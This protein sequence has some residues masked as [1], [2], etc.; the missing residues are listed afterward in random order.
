MRA[1]VIYA[2]KSTE[3]KRG[4]IPTSSTTGRSSLPSGARG[5]GRAPRTRAALADHG[6]RGPVSRPLC[7]V[8]TAVR[9]AWLLRADRSTLRPACARRRQARTEPRRD[10]PVGDKHDVE[11]SAS[12]T[13]RYS[14]AATSRS[15][16]GAI[17][18]MK[19]H[20][21]SKVKSESISRHRASRSARER[22][23]PFV[24]VFRPAHARR[25]RQA[26]DR[27]RGRPAV[28]GVVKLF[29]LEIAD[30]K[31]AGA[32]ARWLFGEGI[33]TT[34]GKGHTYRSVKRIVRNEAYA[35]ARG[36]PPIVCRD[37]F[38]AANA[39]AHDQPQPSAEQ[40]RPAATGRVVCPTR[41]QLLPVR[42]RPLHH[43]EIQ[44]RRA[45]LRLPGE[46]ARHRKAQGR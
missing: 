36:Y 30:G 28:A 24:R 13:P 2:A 40:G 9:G 8:R 44:G 19:G 32:V 26:G 45:V 10:R 39:G 29:E 12:W 6:D 3:D 7:R 43:S 16:M 5:R 18:H 34:Q 1:A 31:D 25:Q 37:L 21:E 41:S 33:T 38:D 14:L 4:S 20:G 11:L 27:A 15:L 23:A 22:T 42:G 35:G 46:G 17:G